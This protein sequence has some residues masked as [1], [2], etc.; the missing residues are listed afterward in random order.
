MRVLAL[1]ILSSGLAWSAVQLPLAFEPNRGQAPSGEF[2]A[3]TR[4]FAVTLLGGSLDLTAQH[5]RIHATLAGTAGNP[6]AQPE[7]PLPA[8]VGYFRGRDP[9]R[10]IKGVPTYSR[11]RYRD[12]YPGIDMVYY[13][14]AGSLEYDFVAGPGADPNR[15]AIRYEGARSLRIDSAGDLVA[16][17][18]D[19]AL[20]L[21]KPAIYQQFAGVRRAVAGRYVL[22]GDTVTFALARFDHTR[23]LVI[24]PAITW[25]TYLSALAGTT[26]IGE[27]MTL[28]SAGNIYI[29]GSM[30][31]IYGDV[32]IFFCK[33]TSSGAQSVL[34]YYGGSGDDYGH[35]IAVDATGAFYLAGETNSYDYPAD[36][37]YN[38]YTGY[39]QD[40]AFITKLD[41]TGQNLVYSHYLGG[42]T[43]DAAYAVGLDSANNAY[44][45]GATASVRFPVSKGAAQT[46]SGGNYDGFVT[47]FDATGNGVYSTYLGGSGNDAIYAIAVDAAGD[48]F[49]TG[50]AGST[51]FPVTGGALQSKLSGSSDAFVAKIAPSTGALVFSTLIGGSADDV[52]NAVAIDAGGA[53]Y[54]TGETTSMD[55]PMMG[56]IQATFGGGGGDIFIAKLNG[57]GQTLAYST[58]FGGSAE[59]YGNAIA[60]DTNGNAYVTGGTISTDFPVTSAFQASNQA[61]TNGIVAGVSPDGSTALF[62]TYLGGDGMEGSAGDYGTAIATNAAAGLVVLGVTSSS[63]FPTSPASLAPAFQG[64]S[65]NAF[66]ANI[67]TT[68]TPPGAL[69]PSTPMV[70]KA[71]PETREAAHPMALRWPGKGTPALRS[72]NQPT[73]QRQPR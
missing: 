68:A 7:Q 31:S 45:A 67:S 5:S 2:I 63:N 50:T 27:A 53:V 9:S 14:N 64:G 17:T 19:G 30:V 46:A 12:V 72:T 35:G 11:V 13:G 73:N 51:N 59:D 43:A 21:H 24:D 52:G 70:R 25:A 18:A 58:Y 3:H 23:T 8:T 60:V 62:A 33:L 56:A 65:S 6:K 15:I 57:N 34:N 41:P 47:E 44:L 42:E 69:P 28:D 10:W 4:G 61:T 66:V 20:R 49:A 37:T 26:E 48:V 36:V 38:S 40:S 54:L 55:F 71:A 1:S 22:R 29:V 32:D 39:S 16:D